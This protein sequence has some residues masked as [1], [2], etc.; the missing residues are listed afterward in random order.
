MTHK[1]VLVNISILSRLSK[2]LF[3]NLQGKY[4]KRQNLILNLNLK[5]NSG[6]H[7]QA[8]VFLLMGNADVVEPII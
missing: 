8:T 5:L 6:I 7:S 1:I 3:S 2:L 4:N